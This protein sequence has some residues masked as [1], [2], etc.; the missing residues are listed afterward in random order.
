[1]ENVV[2]G[3]ENQSLPSSAGSILKGSRCLNSNNETISE[4]KDSVSRKETLLE[5]N[6]S[7][8]FAKSKKNTKLHLLLVSNLLALDLCQSFPIHGTQMG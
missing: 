2:C 3:K 4:E 8:E 1:M 6:Y 5:R 7:L